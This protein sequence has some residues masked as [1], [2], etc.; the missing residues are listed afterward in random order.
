[1]RPISKEDARSSALT[2]LASIRGDDAARMKMLDWIDAMLATY[3]AEVL[4]CTDADVV[5][6]RAAADQLQRLKSG[7]TQQEIKHVGLFVA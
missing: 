2:A 7:L 4:T 1:M 6:I 5:K 3:Q